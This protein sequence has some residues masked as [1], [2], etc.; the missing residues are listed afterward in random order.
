MKIN[1]NTIAHISGYN[2][3]IEVEKDVYLYDAWCFTLGM[4][5]KGELE[6][7]EGVA[8][9][10]GGGLLVLAKKLI[11]KAIEQRGHGDKHETNKA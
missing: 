2:T 11:D 9:N 3:C 4:S 6:H 7:V 5:G 1:G 8:H 10:R